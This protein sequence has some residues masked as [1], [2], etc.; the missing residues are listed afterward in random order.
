MSSPTT[1]EH[2]AIKTAS[3]TVEQRLAM[4]YSSWTDAIALRSALRPPKN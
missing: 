4:A 3:V 1:P 2:P